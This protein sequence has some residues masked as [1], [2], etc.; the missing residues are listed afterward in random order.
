MQKALNG[1]SGIPVDIEPVF[2]TA[3]Q[4]TSAR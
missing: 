2:V 1:L 3:K 4:L